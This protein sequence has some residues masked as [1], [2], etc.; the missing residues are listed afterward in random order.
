MIFNHRYGPISL[1]YSLDLV[2]FKLGKDVF[3]RKDKDMGSASNGNEMGSSHS[4]VQA[5]VEEQKKLIQKLASFF[6]AFF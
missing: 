6:F 4:A 1:C 2:Y 3:K 5:T